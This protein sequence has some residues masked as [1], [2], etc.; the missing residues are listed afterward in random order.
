MGSIVDALVAAIESGGSTVALRSPVA[1]INTDGRRATGV[2][3][4]SGRVLDTG[5]GVV[6]NA[7]V[8]SL[9]A[10]VCGKGGGEARGGKVGAGV[11]GAAVPLSSE[12][13]ADDWPK[14]LGEEALALLRGSSQVEM[15]RS[16]LHL[17]LA[18]DATGVDLRWARN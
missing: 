16:Y 18:L 14:G 12:P 11:G 9:G 15:T 5:G 17:H 2:T 6:C 7:P 4:A 10:L 3:L 8:W 13:V 1:R